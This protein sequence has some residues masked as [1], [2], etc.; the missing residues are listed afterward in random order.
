MG[1]GAGLFRPWAPTMR[2]ARSTIRTVT[3]RK[4]SG[5]AAGDSRS[6][7]SRQPCT[8]SGRLRVVTSQVV[9]RAR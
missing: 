6:I 7:T 8:L 2:Q 3:T 4:R 5:S 1:N 9:G